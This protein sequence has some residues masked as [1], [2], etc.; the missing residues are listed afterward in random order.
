MK[1]ERRSSLYSLTL[2]MYKQQ[3]FRKVSADDPF[4]KPQ[5][6]STF[7]Y[8]IFP[9][10]ETRFEQKPVLKSQ[11]VPGTVWS[12]LR[13]VERC[14]RPLQVGRCWLRFCMCVLLL[15]K[16]AESQLVT[17]GRRLIEGSCCFRCRA[18]MHR[19][20]DN[21]R[22]Q[23]TA[24]QSYCMHELNSSDFFGVFSQVETLWCQG[25]ME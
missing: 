15:K 13:A 3:S 7:H 12:S 1:C 22:S 10:W 24:L 17:V 14:G 20:N 8:E 2:Q 4:R 23:T 5:S 6:F 9:Q 18:A 16:C 19:C 25:V 11:S 21:Y